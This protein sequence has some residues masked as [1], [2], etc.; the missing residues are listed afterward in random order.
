MINREF[1]IE[2]NDC[3]NANDVECLKHV[4][5]E[6]DVYNNVDEYRDVLIDVFYYSFVHKK[7]DILKYLYDSGV[8]D[9]EDII[10]ELLDEYISD[11]K[12]DDL[13]E[14]FNVIDIRMYMTPALVMSSLSDALRIYGRGR[15]YFI[16]ILQNFSNIAYTKYVIKLVLDVVGVSLNF[17]ILDDYYMYGSIDIN[18]YDLYREVIDMFNN[19]VMD[20]EDLS[21]D[22][23]LDMMEKFFANVE[24]DREYMFEYV[25]VEKIL[26]ILKNLICYKLYRSTIYFFSEYGSDLIYFKENF[27]SRF[28]IRNAED[29]FDIVSCIEDDKLYDRIFR[30]LI[31]DKTFNGYLFEL[32]F[33]KKDNRIS[34]KFKENVVSWYNLNSIEDLRII[35]NLML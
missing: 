5:N 14:I 2:I 33:S 23:L 9:F 18:K 16:F 35:K 21:D 28:S 24:C 1:E 6:F 25:K 3:Y 19:I 27:L 12:Y 34:D 31:E 7:Y 17:K 26:R 32:L 20:G 11:Y 15:R 29:I 22:R 30:V 10:K 4:I 8:M 13:I